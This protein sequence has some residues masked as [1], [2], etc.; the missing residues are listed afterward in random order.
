MSRST[1]YQR[2]THYL[3][4]RDQVQSVDL[5][6]FLQRYD[7]TRLSSF[8]LRGLFAQLSIEIEGTVECGD[9]ATIPQ[10]RRLIQG[11]HRAWPWA[12][13]FLDLEPPLGSA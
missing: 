2:Q 10:A 11:L 13:F 9:L 5:R 1:D 7:P 8:Q 12:G 3:F 4:R 6:D